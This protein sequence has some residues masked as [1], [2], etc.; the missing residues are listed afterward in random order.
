MSNNVAP[1]LDTGIPHPL[2][3]RATWPPR[4]RFTAS[5]C[6][7]TGWPARYHKGRG[8]RGGPS[9]R[10]GHL[11]RPLAP[12]WS[13]QLTQAVTAV[14]QPPRDGDRVSTN[15][16]S[17]LAE[18]VLYRNPAALEREEITAGDLDSLAISSCSG[19]RPLRHASI[20]GYEVPSITPVRIRIV[21]EHGGVRSTDSSL[22]LVSLAVDGA[23]PRGL[24]DTVGR[25][26]RHQRIDV[27]TVPGVGECLQQA[28]HDAQHQRRRAATPAARGWSGV[29]LTGRYRS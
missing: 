8:R 19:E 17:I 20:A 18:R 26:H 25:H 2:A 24:E 22:S 23:T 4:E 12:A 21:I 7:L 9:T 3:A 11:R 15:G 28:R 6:E 5:G 29:A 14:V 13:S 27:V 1:R 16:K 10:W